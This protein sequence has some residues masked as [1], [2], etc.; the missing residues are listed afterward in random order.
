M[1]ALMSDENFHGNIIRGLRRR[2]PD[3]DL[4]RAQDVG[5]RG[6]DD[7]A[8][9]EWAAGEGRVLLTH[10]VNTMIE[11]ASARVLAGQRMPGLIA[12]SASLSIRQVIDEVLLIAECSEAEEWEGQIRFLPL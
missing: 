9:L 11:H 1:L 3:L 6:A 5:L 2:R 7:P 10:D 12:V 8:V 4:V